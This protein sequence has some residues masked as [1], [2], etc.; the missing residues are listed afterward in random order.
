MFFGLTFGDFLESK[1]LSN[2]F[3]NLFVLDN[4]EAKIKEFWNI[5][6]DVVESFL[7]NRLKWTHRPDKSVEIDGFKFTAFSRFF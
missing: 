1:S 6:E 7:E 3:I 4:D 5:P 2:E